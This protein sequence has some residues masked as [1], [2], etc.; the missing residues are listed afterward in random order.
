VTTERLTAVAI[1][2][3]KA[4]AIKLKKGISKIE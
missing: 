4:A 1:E 3:I 2:R